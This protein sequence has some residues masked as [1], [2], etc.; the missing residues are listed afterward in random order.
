MRIA[1]PTLPGTD[2]AYDDGGE[3]KRHLS[4]A[5]ITTGVLNADITISGV[6]ATALSGRRVQID[7]Q[8]I[9]A[10]DS[11]G[12]LRVALREQ[13][14]FVASAGISVWS[15]AGTLMGHLGHQTIGAAFGAAVVRAPEPVHGRNSQIGH[16]ER[17]VFRGL[18]NPLTVGRYHSLV[19]DPRSLP[20]DLEV[21]AQTDNGVVMALAHRRW[22]VVGVQFHPESILTLVGKQLLANFLRRLPARAA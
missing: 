7:S 15:P 10:F 3:V 16:N 19:V 17:G 21:T 20:H 18:A 1:R 2:R 4:A 9:R 13:D 6:I 12:T 8:G 22:P 14:Q 11:T 5:K